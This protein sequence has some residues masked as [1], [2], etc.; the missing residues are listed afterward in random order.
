MSIRLFIFISIIVAC[1]KNEKYALAIGECM[2]S[3]VDYLLMSNPFYVVFV[4]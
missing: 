4:Y 3:K 1:V 2:M